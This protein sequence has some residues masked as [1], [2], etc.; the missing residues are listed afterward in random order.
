MQLW[1]F[2]KSILNKYKWYVLSMFLIGA[3]W[4]CYL[5]FSPYMLKMIIDRLTTSGDY[6]QAYLP[7]FGFWLLY[8]S[9]MLSF[10]LYDYVHYKMLPVL[11]KDISLKMFDS[12]KR[13]SHD[14]FQNNFAGS[15]SNKVNDM[16]VNL[17]SL[18]ISSEDFL[19]VIIS[20]CIAV[21]VMYSVNPVF[22]IALFV[23]W[24]LFTSISVWFS[25]RIH[26]LSRDTSAAYSTYSGRLVD[27]I[28]NMSSVRLFAQYDYET[29][30]LEETID[31]LVNKDRKMHRYLIMMRLVQDVT[32][33]GLLG[34]M[35]YYLIRLYSDGG[36]TIGDFALIIPITTSIFQYMRHLAAKLVDI[37][38]SIGKC[39]QALTVVDKSSDIEDF[40]SARNIFIQSAE[41]EFRSVSFAYKNSPPIFLNKNLLIQAGSKIGLVG[42]SG[43]GKSTFISLLLRL[44]D[45][46]SGEIL[47]N[48]TDIRAFTQYSLRR[49][50]SIIPQDVNLF[51]RTLM[52]NI[53]Y[54]KVEATDEEVINA[55][56]L[57]HCHEFIEK[58]DDGYNTIVGE[59]GVKLSG[60][61]R[62][63][64]AIARAF[65]ENAPILVLDEATSSLD[66]VTEKLIQE[67]LQLATLNRTTLVIA[68][69]L[70]TL[71]DMDRILV[72][73]NGVIVE[74]GSHQELMAQNGHYA[75]MWQMQSNGFLP[76]EN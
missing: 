18:V 11:K 34:V 59:R 76:L 74:D 72:F 13:H 3:Y 52:E 39:S 66:S 15:I 27:I 32:L 48:G 69:R 43:S 14:F 26:I 19:S 57:A 63:R 36:V 64:I 35:F 5:N 60:G 33:V 41:I 7:A 17:E 23:W 58:L 47:I 71:L 54:G 42:Y 53:R 50:I 56:K 62:Q 61:Q 73:K 9:A 38:R 37:Y 8:M 10:R 22:G 24:I 20:L 12:I 4:S 28:S 55:S 6:T 65:L 67:S 30:K 29:I 40:S 44:Y 2:A 46:T 70:S 75:K 1:H 21:V 68:H 16:V 25:K 49:N 51:H 31:D 45:V